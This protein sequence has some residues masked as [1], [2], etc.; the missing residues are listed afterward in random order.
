MAH[1]ATNSRSRFANLPNRPVW[2]R[3]LD[4]LLTL[5]ARWRERRAWENLDD[6]LKRDV[7]IETWTAPN[8]FKVNPLSRAQ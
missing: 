3:A 5:D 2:R 8:H 7:G 4:T 6:H 1:V